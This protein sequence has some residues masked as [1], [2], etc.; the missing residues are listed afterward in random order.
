MARAMSGARSNQNCGFDEKVLAFAASAWYSRATYPYVVIAVEKD[1]P[2][3][4]RRID[5]RVALGTDTAI[6]LVL[7]EPHARVAGRVLAHHLGRPIARGVV[8][9]DDL[10]IMEVLRKHAPDG[11]SDLTFA[12]VRGNDD[13]DEGH[14]R[15]KPVLRP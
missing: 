1:H 5:A 4:T 7:H 3:R 10:D 9:D 11:A 14:Q 2:R 15:V 12:V 13:R 6:D 8:G